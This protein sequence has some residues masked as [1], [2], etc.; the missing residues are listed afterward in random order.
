MK[1]KV[2]LFLFG[3]PFFGVGAFMLYLIGDDAVEASQMRGW[4]SARATLSDAGYSSHSGD[5]S[6]TYEAY[7]TYAYE[8]NGVRYVS[9][10]VGLAGGADNIGDYQRDLGNELRA[11]MNAQRPITV[12]YDPEA[13]SEAIIDRE[14]RWGLIGFRSIFV[15]VFGGVGGGLM[16]WAFKAPRAK[17]SSDPRYR[18]APWLANDDWQTATIKSNSRASMFVAWGFA[19]FWNAVSAPLPFVVYREVGQQNFIALAGLLFPLIGIGLAVWAF[20]RTREWKRFGATPV[21]LDPFPGSIGGHVGGT[22]ELGVPYDGTGQFELT[23]TNLKSYISGSGKNRSRRERAEWQDSQV[24]YAESSL[25]GTRLTFQFEVPEGLKESAAEQDSSTYHL[26]R[27]NVHGE[28]EGTNFDRDFEIPVYATA[29]TSTSLAR[30][31]VETARGEQDKLD[32]QRA[33]KRMGLEYGLADRR[34][35]FPMGRNFASGMIGVLIGGTFAAAGW[36]LVV[37]E[38]ERVFGSIFGGVGALV[39]LGTLYM[40]S[41]SLTVW[42]EAGSLHALRRVFGVPV[43]RLKIGLSQVDRFSTNSSMQTQSGGKHRMHYSLYAHA[44]DG[45]KMCVG[46]GFQGEGEA[47]AAIRV[48]CREFSITPRSPVESSLPSDEFDALAADG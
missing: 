7:A 23:L 20:R 48:I 13:P 12:Y 5:D 21:E 44:S 24:A 29:K 42:R 1:G 25:A 16:F 2:F 30:H 28:L 15:L 3:L 33:I 19:A 35:H 34:V 4:S 27:L 9:S 17:D 8:V 18:D 41:N 38:G 22:I 45:T 26:W 47:N 46:E 31:A 6:T 43:R 11:A 32:E 37:S 39:A 36:F 14:L 40:I 10:R